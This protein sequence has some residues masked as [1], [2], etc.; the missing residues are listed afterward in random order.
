MDEQTLIQALAQALSPH[1]QNGPQLYTGMKASGTPSQ[2]A[3][4]YDAGGLFGR[5]DGPAM[6]VNA[7][8]G[9]MGFEGAMNWYGTNTQRE[10]VD[11][12]TDIVISAGEQSTQCGDC[13]SVSLRACAQIYCFGRFCRQTEELQFDR[14]GLRANGNVPVKTLFGAI[15]DA[16]GNVLVPKGEQINDAFYLQART[17]GYALRL[18]NS[19]LLWQGDPANNNGNSYVEYTGLESIVNT[20]KFDAYT[21]LTCDALDSFLMDMQNNSF[22]ADGTYAV[23]TW[24]ER[25]VKQFSFRAERAGLAWDTAQMYIVMTP[26]MWECV[27]RVFA[28]VGLDLCSVGNSENEVVASADQAE[29]RYQEFLTRR[30]LPIMGRWYPVVLDTQITELTGQP[31]GTVSDIFFITTEINGEE[32]TFGQYQDFNMTYGETRNELVSMFGSDDIAITDNG[33]YAM[34][35]DNTRGCF[36]VQVYTKPRVVAVMPWLLGRIQNAACNVTGQP[37]PDPTGSGGIYEPDG[38]T[39]NFIY[40]YTVRLLIVFKCSTLY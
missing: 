40:T 24:F 39:P 6:L 11:A 26:N 1:L 16:S 5:C 29:N 36:D 33:R 18:H 2:N 21:Q 35:R 37:F 31:G 10:F 17:A 8:V 25:V 30:A 20:G 15:T 34:I 13:R 22:T 12:L 9:P 23:R 19:T 14:L 38:G 7:M 27:A 4:L 28:C 32:I 3:Y